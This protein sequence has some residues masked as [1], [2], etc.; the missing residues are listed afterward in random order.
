MAAEQGQELSVL[1]VEDDPGVA[2]LLR[3][4]LGFE[5]YRVHH[6]ETGPAAIDAL[7]E[8]GPDLMV[9]DIMIPAIDGIEVSRRIREAERLS[10]QN[11]I[12]ILMLTAR[13]TVADRVKGLDSGADDYLVKPFALD[14]FLARVRALRRRLHVTDEAPRSQAF[15]FDDVS[16]DIPSRAVN[17]GERQLRLT[18]KEFDLLAFLLKNPNIVLTRN[19][20]LDRVWGSDFWGDSNVIE[21]FV[22]NL[23]REMEAAGEPRLIQTVRGVGYV[24]RR[25]PD[26]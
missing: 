18:P 13:D 11:P 7:K 23:R 5:G 15:A 26:R 25:V 24:L 19:Q 4:S 17:R 6:V 1:V 21:V 20:I 9:L 16:M 14:E 3:R 22:G 8:T 12:P 2:A 10:G